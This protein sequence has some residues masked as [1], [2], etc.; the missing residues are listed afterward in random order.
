MQYRGSENITGGVAPIII[1]LTAPPP[2]AVIMPIASIPKI[3]NLF[4][5]AS[6]A[7]DIAKATVPAI[8]R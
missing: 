5:I 6:M 1:S 7:P 2:T 3:S 8:S 4:S